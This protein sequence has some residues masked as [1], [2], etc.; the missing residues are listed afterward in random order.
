MGNMGSMGKLPRGLRNCNPLNIRHGEPWQGMA[1]VQ[2]DKAFVTFV[3]NAWGYRA[4]FVTLRTYQAKH[5]LRTIEGM[6]GRWAPAC[7]NNTKAY[8]KVV[9]DEVGMDKK[10]VLP[11]TDKEKMVRMVMSMSFVENGVRAVKME[12]EE[13][14]RLAMGY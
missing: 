8:V 13:G 3:S 14:Y 12:V 11:Y 4:A 2:K 9:A 6:I 10:A 7:E 1:E 5:G